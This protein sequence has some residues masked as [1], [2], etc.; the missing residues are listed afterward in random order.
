MTVIGM[1][2]GFQSKVVSLFRAN[3]CQDPQSFQNFEHSRFNSYKVKIL[4]MCLNH[5]KHIFN[6]KSG[7]SVNGRDIRQVENDMGKVVEALYYP[8][9]QPLFRKGH[10]SRE[11]H[12]FRKSSW[13]KEIKGENST[14]QDKG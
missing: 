2:Q 12:F 14:S 7:S 9:W 5:T 6:S 8:S 4:A 1:T 10:H 13:K 3:V 11:Q